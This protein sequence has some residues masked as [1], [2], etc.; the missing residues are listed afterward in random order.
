MVKNNI[1]EA[2]KNLLHVYNRFPVVLDHGEGMYL[3][4]EDGKEY[5]DF[6]AG[7]GVMCLGYHHPV[8][9]EALKNQID[10]LCHTSNLF[11]TKNCGEA[12]E[13]LNKVSGMDRV[14]FTNSGAEAIEGALKSARK[15][16]Y[17][18]GT[19]RYEFIAMEHSFHGRTIGAVSVTGHKE[20]REP[21]EPMLPG[22]KFAEFNNLESV[23]AL[24]N[25]KTC[26]IVLEPL[27]GEGGINLATQEFMEGIRKICD[28][29][30]ILMICDEVQCGMG[31]TGSMFAWQKF[32]V[33]PDIMTMAKGIGNG[34]PVGAF[35]MTEK[36]AEFSM[37]AGDHGSTYGGNPFACMA[38]KTVLDLF[39]KEQILA[40]VN[41]VAP[42]LEK[43]LDA[44][45]ENCE[46]VTQRKGTGFMQG[47]AL[48]KPAGEVVKNA[49][50]EG[51]L[52]VVAE[53]NVVRLLPPLIAEKKHID[54][55]IE[56]LT[57]VLNK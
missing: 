32:G 2:E 13:A 24:V 33:K 35:A 11:F 21:F 52:I 8:Y 27:Q 29:N 14:F 3:Y 55:M 10:K 5:L 20:Y 31:R 51:L 56:K 53:G 9:T 19:G 18:K 23:K 1:Q 49:I 57:K 48:T 25:E 42:Y 16:A 37:K 46:F 44:L 4:D 54:E 45:V 12:A 28:E 47:L 15:Y 22:A 43:C 26:A 17:T 38:V 41:E 39:E 6:L 50:D 30:D 36:V 34:V 40:H 7:I